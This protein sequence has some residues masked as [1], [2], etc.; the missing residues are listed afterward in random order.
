MVTFFSGEYSLIMVWSLCLIFSMAMGWG[1][2][3][4][5]MPSSCGCLAL[6]KDRLSFSSCHSPL[7]A[8]NSCRAALTTPLRGFRMHLSRDF[9]RTRSV[10]GGRNGVAYE[11]TPDFTLQHSWTTPCINFHVRQSLVGLLHTTWK[12]PHS[13]EHYLQAPLPWPG[14]DSA[15][16]LPHSRNFTLI[17]EMP[18]SRTPSLFTFVTIYRHRLSVWNLPHETASLP[19]FQGKL[20]TNTRLQ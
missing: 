11:H 15:L 14:P 13:H 9:S 10:E 18:V 3:V 5:D 4:S 7:R 17:W 19:A 1:G 16:S 12:N 20:R 6:A 2:S 8:W